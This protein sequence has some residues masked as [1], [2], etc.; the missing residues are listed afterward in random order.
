[1]L[2]PKDLN[3]FTCDSELLEDEDVC[4]KVPQKA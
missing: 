2:V 1:M 4:N 3:S